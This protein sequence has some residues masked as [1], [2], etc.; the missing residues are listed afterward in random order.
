MMAIAMEVVSSRS[1]VGGGL[2]GMSSTPSDLDVSR[3][4]RWAAVALLVGDIPVR[5]TGGLGLDCEVLFGV[6]FVRSG[7]F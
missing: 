4:E 1:F 6:G 5:L 7:P 2:V 3:G